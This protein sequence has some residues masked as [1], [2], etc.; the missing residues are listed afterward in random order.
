MV[1]G[2]TVREVWDQ[3]KR[4][5]GVR[6]A[7]GMERALGRAAHY[8]RVGR[9]MRARPPWWDVLKRINRTLE[10]LGFKLIC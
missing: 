9:V 5:V 6:M 2:P 10:G 8:E 7:C 1:N 3:W 4:L